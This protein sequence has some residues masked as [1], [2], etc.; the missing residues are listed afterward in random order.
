MKQS[1]KEMEDGK[2]AKAKYFICP[3]CGARV[4]DQRRVRHACFRIHLKEVEMDIVRMG[5]MSRGG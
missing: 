1:H 2:Q 5:W 4:L 3:R